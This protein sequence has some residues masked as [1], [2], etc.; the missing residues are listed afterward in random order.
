MFDC[1]IQSVG[2]TQSDCQCIIGGLT[3]ETV[4]KLRV[5]TT[6]LYLDDIPDALS[7]KAI[8][9]ADNCKGFAALAIESRDDATKQFESDMIIAISNHFKKGAKNFNGKVSRPSFQKTLV[10]DR[11]FQG[12]RMVGNERTDG[13]M[14]VNR[15]QVVGTQ[16]GPMVLTVARTLEGDN[17]F[18]QLYS[19][20]FEALENNFATVALPVGG[21][22]LPLGKDLHAYDYRIY[23]DRISLPN[24]YPKDTE[25][26]CGCRGSDKD[27]LSSYVIT[28]GISFLD[29]SAMNTYTDDKYSHGIVM[30]VEVNCP[31]SK[32]FCR[33]YN[34]AEEIKEMTKYAIA[35]KANEMLNERVLASPE[36]NRF[37]MQ[38]R[39]YL[40]GKRNHFRAKYEGL[41][42][43]IA[44]RIDITSSDCFECRPSTMWKA[45]VRP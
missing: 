20:P 28:Q 27:V 45:K 19:L 34:N 18:E 9:R 2:I 31:T 35:Y 24:F 40:W 7:F 29:T 32:I 1:I 13:D 44:A 33:E 38:N 22:L 41:V 39:E 42:E 8:E 17:E 37:T 26:G 11:R 21:L 3:P 12:M 23:Y 30:D 14:K 4:D 43:F 15:I 16:A 25:M 5:S 36:V 6:G 10:D